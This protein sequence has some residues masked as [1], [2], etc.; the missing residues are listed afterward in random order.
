[1]S[2]TE[3]DRLKFID[4]YER[5][6]GTRLSINDE[7]L[8]ILHTIFFAG[9]A[10]E[11]RLLETRR[12]LDKSVTTIEFLNQKLKAT[13]YNFNTDNSALKWQLGGLLKTASAGLMI[14]AIIWSLYF[15][16]N[17]SLTRTKA[18]QILNNVE[19]I[20]KGLLLN[21]RLTEDGYYF[22]ESTKSTDSSIAFF[23]EYEELSKGRIRIYVGKK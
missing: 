9:K 1:M 12:L 10:T 3:G 14:I 2:W 15:W 20:D 11:L 16:W 7:M 5:L 21:I 18:L 17:A 13:T 19:V 23:S 22:I 6:Y 8:P 4:E